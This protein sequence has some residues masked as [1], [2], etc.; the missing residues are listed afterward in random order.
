M[1][2]NTCNPDNRYDGY[3][4]KKYENLHTISICTV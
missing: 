3:K 2:E 1:A 4:V